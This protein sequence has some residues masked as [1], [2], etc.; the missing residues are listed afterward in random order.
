MGVEYTLITFVFYICALSLAEILI[1]R[2]SHDEQFFQGPMLL[3]SAGV[4]FFEFAY[5]PKRSAVWA[6]MV[7]V[8]F[9]W[10]M[11]EVLNNDY[12]AAAGA[13]VYEKVK[14]PAHTE[15]I[16][17]AVQVLLAAASHAPFVRHKLVVQLGGALWFLAFA[18]PQARSPS[19]AF[20]LSQGLL[21][22][23]LYA[24][25]IPV[26]G[27]RETRHRELESGTLR[28]LQSGWV[29]AMK[30]SLL[31]AFFAALT[32]IVA[33]V[34]MN[35]NFDNLERMQFEH[36]NLAEANTSVRKEGKSDAENP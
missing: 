36:N 1:R 15:E 7:F 21:F 20:M 35:A 17:G 23:T 5:Y 13:G 34:V 26:V 27:S 8:W 18:L 12:T 19:L 4:I 32:G 25:S 31:I 28:L 30:H 33:T 2:V 9:L 14:M 10:Q 6:P 29:L 16:A 22:M 24:L 11:R 3:G